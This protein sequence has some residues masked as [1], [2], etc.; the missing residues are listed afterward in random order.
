[1]A[2]APARPRL[3]PLNALRAFEAAARTESFAQAAQELAVTPAAVAQQVKQLEAWLGAKLFQRLAQGLRLTDRGRAAL[4]ALVQAFDALGGAVRALNDAARPGRIEIA[5]LPAVAM[6]WLAPR[7]RALR[8]AFPHMALSITALE[9]PPN[10]RREPFDLAIFYVDARLRGAGVLPLAPDRMTPVCS[11]SLSPS[12]DLPAWLAQ[13]TLLHD[14]VWRSDWDIWL[15][16]AG[17]PGLSTQAGPCFSLYDLAVQAAIDGAGVLM[18]HSA[19][20]EAPLRDGRL[21]APFARQHATGKRLA[22]LL[23]AQPA[24]H[25][26]ALAAWLRQGLPDSGGHA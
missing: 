7:L 21:I 13:Q 1:M 24:L 9:T 15:A 16:A 11:P 3:P 8:Q 2:L 25:V 26:A 23:P 19:L 14:S 12:P 5:A 10:L 17:L 4:P 22:L 6:L 18:G 20:L